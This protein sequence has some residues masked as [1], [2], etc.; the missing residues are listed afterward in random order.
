MTTTSVEKQI[1]IAKKYGGLNDEAIEKI[2]QGDEALL[3]QLTVNLSNAILHL[4]VAIEDIDHVSNMVPSRFAVTKE[5][6]RKALTGEITEED[7]KDLD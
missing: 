3:G 1:E 7:L 4:E 6:H 2:K 5:Q